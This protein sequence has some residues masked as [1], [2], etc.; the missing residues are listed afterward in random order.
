MKFEDG[1]CIPLSFFLTK[2]V[3][4]DCSYLSL[5]HY[6][7]IQVIF[8]RDTG[9]SSLRNSQVLAPSS[10]SHRASDEEDWFINLAD[11]MHQDIIRRA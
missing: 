2:S 7:Y 4:E 3:D 8:L 11:T 5:R 10:L 6:V 9:R 1:S